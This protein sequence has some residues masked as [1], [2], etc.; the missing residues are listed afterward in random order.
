M[1]RLAA[2]MSAQA[3]LRTPD[4]N[5]WIAGLV[6]AVFALGWI[7]WLGHLVDATHRH[8]AEH[9]TVEH[10]P[11]EH[12]HEHGP[13]STS[14]PASDEDPHSACSVVLLALSGSVVLSDI[15]SPVP[16]SC[17]FA[18]EQPPAASDRVRLGD[19]VLLYAPKHSPPVASRFLRT[20]LA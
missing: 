1:R 19:Q 20:V 16:V 4:T 9:R 14:E 18:Y 7:G 5:R 10:A 15:P 13:C 8:C 2:L 3:R 11:V 6:L 12:A 17:G